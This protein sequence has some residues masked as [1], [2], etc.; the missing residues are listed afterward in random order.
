MCG[1]L[2][3]KTDLWAR[4]YCRH[5]PAPTIKAN[6]YRGSLG[7]SARFVVSFR[8]AIVIYNCTLLFRI[9][10][11]RFKWGT[12]AVNCYVMPL[13]T[14]VNMLLLVMMLSI[15]IQKWQSYNQIGIFIYMSYILYIHI[16]FIYTYQRKRIDHLLSILI[17]HS[18]L[19]NGICSQVCFP[20]SD[21]W[22]RFGKVCFISCLYK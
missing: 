8:L 12:S 15:Y 17:A 5:F 14:A 19:F 16:W 7:L 9:S 2:A 21:H 6:C 22:E 18:R 13:I 1:F 10:E 11:L 20:T 4:F 3:P